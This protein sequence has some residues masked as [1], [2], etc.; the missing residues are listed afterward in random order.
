MP[1]NDI[2]LFVEGTRQV[3]EPPTGG[4]C[5]AGKKA[6]SR[7]VP[8][9]AGHGEAADLVAVLD[10]QGSDV[11]AGLRLNRS[12][13]QRDVRS[14]VRR[15]P[16]GQTKII[17]ASRRLPVHDVRLVDPKAQLV[18]ASERSVEIAWKVALACSRGRRC[19]TSVFAFRSRMPV[20]RSL[21]V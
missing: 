15:A 5:W 16:V 4:L 18:T 9:A 6:S 19:T 10:E 2:A 14:G 7:S 1:E 12:R 8:D 3:R 17:P 20:V 11:D 13:V 21:S